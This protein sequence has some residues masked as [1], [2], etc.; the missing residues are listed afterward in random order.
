M[1]YF[2]SVRFHN[3]KNNEL[4][5]YS[6]EP[7]NTRSN[8]IQHL[9]VELTAANPMPIIELQIPFNV[10]RLDAYVTWNFDGLQQEPRRFIIPNLI[11]IFLFET[12]NYA[13]AKIKKTLYR[14]I[15]GVYQP[16]F[17]TLVGVPETNGSIIIQ[18][19]FYS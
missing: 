6:M 14:N 12:L 18:F 9:S 15:N 16:I 11:S 2:L 17:Q 8:T 1:E 4:N 3:N 10:K 13:Q 19:T 7:S 5:I